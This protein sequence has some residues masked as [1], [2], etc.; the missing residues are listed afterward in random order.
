MRPSGSG[1]IYLSPI[2]IVINGVAT[3]TSWQPER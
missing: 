1:A 3:D 2:A